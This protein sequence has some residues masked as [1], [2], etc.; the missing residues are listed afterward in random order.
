[1]A[2]IQTQD[3]SDPT[4]ARASVFQVF[5]SWRMAVVLLMGFASGLPLAL[6]STTLQAWMTDA[7]IKLSTIGLFS[8]VGLP[9]TLK[10]LWS[11]IMD[12]FAPPFLDRR[13]GWMLLT[14]LC[15]ALAV[16]ALALAGLAV[17][18]LLIAA[19]ALIVAFCSASQDITIDAYRTELLGPA[20]LGAGASLY[21]MG[22]RIGMICSAGIS[23]ILAQYIAWRDVYL[24]MAAAVGATVLVTALAPRPQAVRPPQTLSQAVWLPFWD[25]LWLRGHDNA[26]REHLPLGAIL[27]R[28]APPVEMLLF[29]LIYKLDWAMVAGM[30]TTFLMKIGFTK[31]DIGKIANGFGIAASIV[32]ALVGGI[33]ITRIGL[34]RSLWTFGLLQ[35]LAGSS[36][37]ALALLGH[38]YPMMVTAIAV[39]SV[40]SGM[41]TAA[42]VA[43]IMSLCNK[44]YT[45]T[46]YALLSS[47]VGLCRIVGTAPAGWLA[48]NI[49]WAGFFLVSIL[50]A[51]PGL[52]LLLRYNTWQKTQAPAALEEPLETAAV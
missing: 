52:L 1:M 22:Y 33:I 18:P 12:R 41:A 6:T 25:F 40:C 19:L 2:I 13:R 31:L 27:A 15:L 26:P 16:A 32:G 23:L 38:S 45:A 34:K 11:P 24:I 3:P 42:L 28:I 50:I 43:F 48:Q 46:Q 44:R 7:N 14:Q 20:E 10:F 5:M 35:S 4:A 36:F 17:N 8:L 9:Y 47:L 29:I 37:L 30:Q 51:I 21:T 39:E 49:G